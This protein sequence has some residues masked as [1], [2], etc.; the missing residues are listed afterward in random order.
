MSGAS[1]YQSAIV[2]VGARNTFI[3][4]EMHNVITER[5]Y[6]ED[7]HIKYYCEYYRE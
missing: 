3:L 2:A 7:A 1:E 6:T 4:H 5:N